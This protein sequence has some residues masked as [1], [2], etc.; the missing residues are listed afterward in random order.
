[1]TSEA[2]L[3]LWLARIADDVR[4]LE[5]ERNDLKTE[6]EE[7]RALTVSQ[8]AELYGYRLQQFQTFWQN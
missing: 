7:L 3:L 8:E 2:Q 6:V 4:K 5:Q 1:M